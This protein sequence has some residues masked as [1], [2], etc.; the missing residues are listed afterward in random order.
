[1]QKLRRRAGRI[2]RRVR[3]T[4]LGKSAV[5]QSGDRRLH[6]PPPRVDPV[7]ELEPLPAARYVIVVGAI[8]PNF[9]GRTASIL[10]KCRLLKEIGGVDSTIVTLN[11]APRVADMPPTSGNGGSW[12]TA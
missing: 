3:R 11:Y 6:R 4:L 1:M 10:T 12:P 2:V 9:G 8:P 5:A 7:P